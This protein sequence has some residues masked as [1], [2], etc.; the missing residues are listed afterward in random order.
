M[1]SKVV[2]RYL[3][4]KDKVA[5]LNHV[6]DLAGFEAELEAVRTALGKSKE[7]FDIAIKPNASMFVRR[8]DD[9]TTTDPILVLALV[10]RLHE[11]GYP[12]ISV[13]E[14]SN[15]YE[16]TFSNRNPVTVMT[17]MGLNGGVHGIV[18]AMAETTAHV[19][20]KDGR[21]LPYRLVDLG[22]DT[23]KIEAPD[24]PGGKLKLA[25]AWLKA[26]FRISFAKFKTHV[27]G[28]YTLLV[29]NTYGCLPETD[30]MWHYHRPT[31]CAPPTLVQL[32]ACPVHFGIIDGVIAADGWMGVKWDRAIPRRPG[33]VMAGKNM[34]E[35]ERAACRVMGVDVGR[36]L[37]TQ[38][39]VDL[40]SEPTEF[41]GEIRPLKH[42]WNVPGFIVSGFPMTEK[43]YYYY[44]FQQ[45]VSDGLGTP[46]F[47]RKPV[48]LA[49][50]YLLVIPAL[51][52][53]FHRRHWVVRKFK[54][55][56]LRR[57][58]REKGQAPRRVRA[59]L[60][61]LDLPELTVLLD[62][63]ESDPTQIPEIYGHKL[64]AGGRWFALP[65]STFSRLVRIPEILAAL[66]DSAERDCCA[67]E[68]RARMEVLSAGAGST[69][70]DGRAAS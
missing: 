30:K 37:M 36:S 33:F 19:A 10:A 64:R 45:T 62:C 20:D 51:L 9:G 16:L 48:G 47:K 43:H 15:A 4:G 66:N 5:L 14:S 40:Y 39:A 26:D 22:A 55:L 1:A 54:D 12:K 67:G 17:A 63:L 60:D 31:G 29:K 44:T 24:M 34:V 23:T 38:E 59:D 52:Y 21:L 6:L 46:P 2:L 57:A 70:K 7:D 56:R 32:A 8:D 68:V 50:T 25:T 27:Y 28:G 42:W 58:I 41:D 13:V 69:A 61:R 3:D 65:D 11:K 49:L 35:T 18:A 53:A